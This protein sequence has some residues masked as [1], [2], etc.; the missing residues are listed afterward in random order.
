M[1]HH[2]PGADRIHDRERS[3]RDAAV[4]RRAQ[5][6]V[7]QTVR[8]K[9]PVRPHRVEPPGDGVDRGG[10]QAFAG[11][12]VGDAVALLGADRH[13]RVEMLAAVVRRLRHLAGGRRIQIVDDGHVAVRLDD[14]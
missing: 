3:P 7:V 1:V 6:D 5:H 14:R 8:P 4:G 9:P 12:H 11:P 13:G 2:V 10:G